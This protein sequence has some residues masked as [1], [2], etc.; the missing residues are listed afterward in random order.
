MAALS[1]TL[2][3]LSKLEPLDGT[4]FKRW[5]QKLL[6]FFE[7]LDVDYI[8][9]TDPPE[10]PQSTSDT[11]T[12][13]VTATQTEQTDPMMN[14]RRNMKRT[15]KRNH[16]K[17]KKKDLNL[18]E[19]ISHMRTE[20]A[21]R[22]KDKELSNSSSNSFKANLVESSTSNKDRRTTAYQYYQR[23]DQ[24]K[25]NHK[26]NAQTT[27]QVNLAETEEVIA[28][29]VMEANLVENK[30]DW[31]LDTGASKHFCSNKELFQELKEAADGEC[32]YMGNSATAGVLGKGKV[33]LKLTSEK[34]LALQDVLLEHVNFDSIKRLK[35]M[36]PINTSEASKYTKCS[37]CV[38]SKFV[39][40]PFKPITQR[41][42]ELLE[43][44]HSD[45]ADF[46][47]TLSKGGKKYYISFVDDYSRYTKIYLLRT[48]DEATEMFL[49]YKCEV[50]NQLDKRIK[51]LSDKGGE[52]STNLLKE[53]CENN[54]II[55]ETSAPYTP[56]QNGIAE[57]KNRTLMEM[58]NAML[59]SSGEADVILGV[60][61]RKTENGFSLC[62]SHHIEKILK[63]FGCH[64]EIPVRTPYDP[65]ACLKK[66]KGDSVSQAE[67][68]KIMGSVMFLMNYTRPDIAYA[69]SRL[70][71]YTHNPNK[72][73]WDAL[74]RL[75]RYL[76]GT[77]N[78]CLHF[79]KYPVVL[80]GF[81]DANWVTD[82]D[83]V[84]ST[85]GY[86]FTLGGGAISWKSAKQTCIAR[87]TMESEFIALELVGQEAEW[88]RNLVGDV[89]LWGSS[90]PVS[91][92]CDS[93]AA[94][95]IAKNYTYN[96]KRRH[97]RIRHGAVKELLKGGIISL[98]YVR[99]ERNLADPLTKGLT[100]RIILETSRAMGL[101][102]LE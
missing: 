11:S 82:N 50:E 101:K 41:C 57:R 4:N 51:R 59:L 36:N 49:K 33:L 1:R 10:N 61:I 64:D 9:F 13:I 81:C 86:V 76:K 5:S 18:Q 77:I 79:N 48:K 22:L 39:K 89:P 98:E 56:Q 14:L 6:I 71:Q 75:L 69:V 94:I 90:V 95:E 45:L 84:S 55:H 19:L 74:R 62:Q 24:Q 72:E 66:N 58:M 92:H 65:S 83:E 100:R 38:E 28:V 60:K 53:F 27:P 93:Q 102:P 40:K 20:E 46:K 54:G 37:I 15:T 8:L 21:N 31:I 29:V 32:I 96:G 68:A 85:S 16:L 2:P 87:S 25:S 70:S 23:K 73:H 52:Y 34:T 97:I 3:D 17:H 7:Q 12:A 42:T 35:S 47:N 43:L 99:S 26:H 91:L 63:K 88:L 44:I 78:L 67:Y 30:S 80:E